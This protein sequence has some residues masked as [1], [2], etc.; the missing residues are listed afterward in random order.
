[1]FKFILMQPRKIHIN[2]EEESSVKMD[3]ALK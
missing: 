2:I 3:L 1:M